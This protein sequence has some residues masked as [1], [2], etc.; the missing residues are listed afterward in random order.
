MTAGQTCIQ[1]ELLHYRRRK[2]EQAAD[3]PYRTAFFVKK[4]TII[5]TTD[6]NREL[7]M[8]KRIHHLGHAIFEDMQR[9]M[10]PMQYNA[11]TDKRACMKFN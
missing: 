2:R 1:Y 7:A 10:Q 6:G 9:L 4:G 3:A 11:V 5:N 8:S